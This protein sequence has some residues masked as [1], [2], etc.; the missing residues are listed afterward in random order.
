[1]NFDFQE[2]L[3]W[4]RSRGTDQQNLVSLLRE[5]QGAYGAIPRWTVTEAAEAL[6]VKETFLLA[7][8]RRIP[9]LRLENTHCLEICGGPNC[10]RRGDLA[11]LA[12][13]RRPGLTVKLVPCMKHCGQ[14]PNIRFDGKIYHGATEALIR[15][16]LEE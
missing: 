13:L 8:I 7:I 15:T 1:M 16:L 4:Y 12:D 14:G 10:S 3:S 6:G 9:S 11:R 2:A 5:I